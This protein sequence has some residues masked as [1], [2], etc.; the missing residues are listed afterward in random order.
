MPYQIIRNDITKVEADVIVN[1][2]NPHPVIGLGTDSAIY[3][4]AGEKQLLAERKKIG[5]IAR[6]EVAV[7]PAFNLPAKYIIHTVGPSWEGGDHGE[8]E[9][10]HACYRNSLR[11]AAELKAES[12]AFP[13][14]ATGVYGFPKDEALKI[15]IAEIQGF[16]LEHDMKVILVVFDMTAFE[17]SGKLVGEIDQFI[18]E[19]GVGAAKEAEYGDFD[20]EEWRRRRIERRREE[21][22]REYHFPPAE[23]EDA[24]EKEDCGLDDMLLQSGETFQQQLFKYMKDKGLK[25]ATV[26]KRANMDRKLFSKISKNV[27]YQPKKKTALA[28]AIALELDLPETEDLISRAGFA[29][30][31]SNRSDLIVEYFVTQKKYDIME[32]DSALF[33]YGQPTL[34]SEE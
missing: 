4:A 18:D 33:D 31:P 3:A 26:Y 11:K 10:L 28:L 17:L 13:L 32:I 15:A 16:V 30:S 25:N 22:E 24:R 20:S 2:A 27:D 21:A 14:I 7:T 8:R 29:L 12:I 23:P 9:I 19:H 5:D 34:F 6:G 1:T